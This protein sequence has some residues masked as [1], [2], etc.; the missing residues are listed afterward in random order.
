VTATEAIQRNKTSALVALLGCS[1]AIGIVLAGTDPYIHSRNQQFLVQLFGN[2][3]LLG[4][5]FWWL[6]LDSIEHGVRRSP[7]LNVGIVLAALIFVPYYFFGTRPHGQRARP[8]LGFFAL[9]AASVLCSVAGMV[10]LAIVMG[11]G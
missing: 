1:F 3:L 9:I 2:A 11:D 5:G 6:R 10:A 4:I 7:L 8:V